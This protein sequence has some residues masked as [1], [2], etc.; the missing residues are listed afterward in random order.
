MSILTSRI[1]YYTAYR[2]STS[3]RIGYKHLLLNAIIL[4]SLLLGK[5]VRITSHLHVLV[6]EMGINRCELQRQNR[7]VDFFLVK[8]QVA[9]RRGNILLSKCLLGFMEVSSQ[10]LMD[11]I[12]ERLP[13]GMRP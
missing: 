1:L 8:A 9:D 10:V 4:P 2:R 6:H 12:G 11:I 5:G 13:H 7:L 3:S